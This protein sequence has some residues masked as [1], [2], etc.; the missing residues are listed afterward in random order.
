MV[1]F[2]NAGRVWAASIVLGGCV[3]MGCGGGGGSA[4]TDKQAAQTTPAPDASAPAA[5]AGGASS[6]AAPTNVADLFPPGPGREAVLNSC[7]SCHNVAC[8]TIGQ[9]TKSRWEGLQEGHADKVSD[10]ELKAAFEYLKANFNDEKPEPK[11]PPDFLQG[12]CT[13]P[14]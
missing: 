12:G 11:V 7:G 10:E 9:R 14:G 1:T 6:A 2:M 13:P 4:A 8:S 3:A 5:D